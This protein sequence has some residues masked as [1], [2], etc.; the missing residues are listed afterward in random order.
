MDSDCLKH[1]DTKLEDK[2]IQQQSPLESPP[3][4]TGASLRMNSA[5]QVNVSQVVDHL[6]QLKTER[7]TTDNTP[8]TTATI[9]SPKRDITDTTQ[10]PKGPSSRASGAAMSHVEDASKAPVLKRAVKGNTR[11]IKG[12]TRD[13]KA[14]TLMAVHTRREDTRG[15]WVLE[16]SE[17]VKL[18]KLPDECSMTGCICPVLDDLVVVYKDITLSFSLSTKQWKRLKQMPTSR[19]VS[20]AVVVNEKLFVMGGQFDGKESNVCEIFHVKDN[21]W[22]SAASLPVP[23]S[24]PLVAVLLGHI[25]ILPQKKELS[26]THTQLLVYDPLLKNYTSRAPLPGNIRSTDDACLV[27]VANMLY[28]LGGVERLSWQ[29][30]LHTNQWIQLVTP[31]ARY[32]LRNGCCAVVRANNILLCGAYTCKGLVVKGNMIEEYST[33]TQ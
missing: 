15:V 13:M 28:L 14:N 17:W 5:E 7:D 9:S 16:N 2:G 1:L 3:L 20:S 19:Q 6:K 31:T 32:S 23:L 4:H 21:K 25:Y 30:N 26:G 24:K 29:H 22:S 10:P 33:V 11:D 12:S 18:C 27:G 8:Q